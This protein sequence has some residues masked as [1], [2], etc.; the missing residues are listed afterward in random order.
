MPVCARC[1]LSVPNPGLPE[2]GVVPRARVGFRT[3]GCPSCETPSP[4]QD[5]PKGRLRSPFQPLS[6]GDPDGA[7]RALWGQACW[8]WGAPAV[9]ECVSVCEC[10]CVCGRSPDILSPAP[11]HRTACL[12][13]ETL[14][15]SPRLPRAVFG[16]Q[17]LLPLLLKELQPLHLQDV[18]GA[19][20]SPGL[21]MRFLPAQTECTGLEFYLWATPAALGRGLWLIYPP[22]PQ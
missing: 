20:G 21:D 6:Q 2:K 18:G 14:P 4:A 8:C 11:A 1:P 10:V 9:S 12:L 3:G 16:L 13:S 17:G 7:P 15:G 22:G 5:P 19:P